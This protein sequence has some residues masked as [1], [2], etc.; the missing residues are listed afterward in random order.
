MHNTGNR[1]PDPPLEHAVSD[2]GEMTSTKGRP[3]RLPAR[4]DD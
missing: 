3:K 2:G 1:K 4:V